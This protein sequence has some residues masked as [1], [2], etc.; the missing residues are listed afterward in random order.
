MKKVFMCS[1]CMG[2]ILG[3]ALYLEPNSVT[4]R[5]NKLTVDKKYRNL[6]LPIK[7]IK[8]IA[9]KWIVFPI[10]TFSMANGEKYKIMIYNKNRFVKSY[11]EYISETKG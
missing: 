11:K 10:A 3:G 2:G 9:W 5:T 7:E 6:V 4:Y 8:D 1:L